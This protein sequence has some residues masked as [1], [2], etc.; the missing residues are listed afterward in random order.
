MRRRAAAAG[1]W[2][3]WGST[4]HKPRLSHSRAPA[5]AVLSGRKRSGQ[6][7]H[8]CADTTAHA[9]PYRGVEMRRINQTRVCRDSPGQGR[10][11]RRAYQAVRETP[12]PSVWPTCRRRAARAG[13]PRC[14]RVPAAASIPKHSTPSHV[15]DPH[16]GVA[17]DGEAIQAPRIPSRPPHPPGLKNSYSSERLVI[18]QHALQI[19]PYTRK[20]MMELPR[21]V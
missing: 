13:H 12:R 10:S 7:S 9:T 1:G 16:E 19:N 6:R 8:R 4:R 15:S 21:N 5:D 2:R 14:A 20:L 11:R 17:P 18:Q 3:R